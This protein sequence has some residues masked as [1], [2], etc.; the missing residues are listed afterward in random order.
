MGQRGSSYRNP[1][2]EGA[3][4]RGL[5]CRCCNIQWRAATRPRGPAGRDPTN[6]S[7]PLSP[8][9]LQACVHWPNSARSQR[10]KELFMHSEPTPG[11]ANRMETRERW[12]WSRGGRAEGQKETL[13]NS[14]LL[15]RFQAEGQWI[16]KKEYT[17]T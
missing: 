1:E 17:C 4:W 12:T 5:P 14:C 7:Q 10:T 6:Q 15:L 3:V 13:H 8:H 9:S 16:P 11:T 2:G